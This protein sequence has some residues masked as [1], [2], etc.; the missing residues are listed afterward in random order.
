M[1]LD[2]KSRNCSLKSQGL[3]SNMFFCLLAFLVIQ[4]L[5][6]YKVKLSILIY[7]DQVLSSFILIIMKV[8]CRPL[9]LLWSLS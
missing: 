9:M 2:N 7:V 5:V 3:A 6:I 8:T 1:V 4:I